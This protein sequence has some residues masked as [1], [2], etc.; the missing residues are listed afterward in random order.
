MENEKTD[1]PTNSEA[2][3]D[4]LAVLQARLRVASPEIRAWGAL[5]FHTVTVQMRSDC[6]LLLMGPSP[7]AAEHGTLQRL[8][9]A[10][11]TSGD[12][13]VN[14]WAHTLANCVIS[15]S[16][17]EGRLALSCP[18][19]GSH[20]AVVTFHVKPRDIAAVAELTHLPSESRIISP[21]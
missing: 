8:P 12:D 2:P 10:T 4:P 11:R 18:V 16:P 5:M 15:P 21:T 6:P 17:V 13:P 20:G 19:P 7:D 14:G 3:L 9:D 1:P